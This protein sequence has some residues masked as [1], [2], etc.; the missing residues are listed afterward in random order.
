VTSPAASSPPALGEELAALAESLARRAGGLVRDGRT[1]GLDDVETKSSLTDVVTEYDRASE[2][3]IVGALR[4]AR[5]DDGLIGE[6]GT[7][8]AGESGVHWLIDPIDGTTNY[9][10]ALPAYSVS[11]AA[12]DATGKL[13][14]AVYCPPTDEMF[15]AHRGGGARLNGAPIQ[16][17]PINVIAAALV[18]TGFAY[19]PERRAA[20]GRRVA[21]LL[22][23]VRDIRRF[24]SAALDLCYVAA[25]RFDAYYEQWLNP[26][27]CA[28]GELIAA[29][30]GARSGSFP[31]AEGEPAGLVV[32]APGVFD[33]LL[34][35]L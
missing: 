9:L 28:A 7:S 14:G 4:E 5:P 10:Y 2:E 33:D 31:G 8:I 35:L 24:G 16:C 12:A 32:A 30:A 26:W 1:R 22:P 19:Q 29:E 25:G 21:G 6:E 15:V 23:R 18:A 11:I 17:S 27:D 20:Q 34:A 3:L 13:A